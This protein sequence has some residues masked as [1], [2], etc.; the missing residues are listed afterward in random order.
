[1][2]DAKPT[3]TDLERDKA[4]V[5]CRKWQE[6]TK[7]DVDYSELLELEKGV[8]QALADARARRDE[9]NFPPWKKVFAEIFPNCFGK[10]NGE[11][12]DNRE[13]PTNK[14]TELAKSVYKY[15]QSQ[16]SHSAPVE[17]K[18]SPKTDQSQTLNEKQPFIR[19]PS[20]K[21]IDTQFG[22]C[23]G[24][25]IV[26]TLQNAKEVCGWFR[27]KIKAVVLPNTCTFPDDCKTHDQRYWFALGWACYAD[28]VEKLNK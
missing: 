25:K 27:S 12:P 18:E 26:H 6:T 21:E 28:A 15:I 2:T 16:L 1:M 20:D 8:A 9:V 14:E 22:M 10:W 23:L 11:T 24:G 13:L 3:P 4:R 7:P 5:V 17:S 19:G